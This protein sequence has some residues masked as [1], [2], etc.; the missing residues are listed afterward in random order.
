[1]LSNIRTTDVIKAKYFVMRNE[2]TFTGCGPPVLSS[3][4]APAGRQNRSKYQLFSCVYLQFRNR[5]W[6]LWFS[7]FTSINIPSD[8][9]RFVFFMFMCNI[10]YYNVCEKINGES[11]SYLSSNCASFLRNSDLF[12]IRKAQFLA[13]CC[14][15]C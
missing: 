12:V 14:H 5:W 7:F 3:A 9:C 2:V 4:P 13:Q 10:Y 1:M 8:I 11:F 15:L 6:L